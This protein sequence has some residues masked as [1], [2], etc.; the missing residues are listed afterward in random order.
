MLDQI[1][2]DEVNFSCAVVAVLWALPRLWFWP[3]IVSRE[4]RQ[5][6]DGVLEEVNHHI[7]RGEENDEAEGSAG[8]K[9]YLEESNSK[10]T[11]VE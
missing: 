9:K 11:T 8:R 3:I 4:T 5:W 7:A 2:W 6:P 1:Q 10:I